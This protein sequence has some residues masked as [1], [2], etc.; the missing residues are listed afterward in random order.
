MLT[1]GV[2]RFYIAQD[3]K[4]GIGTL[5]PSTTLDVNGQIRIA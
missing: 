2:G 4:V 5:S 1:N 3:G